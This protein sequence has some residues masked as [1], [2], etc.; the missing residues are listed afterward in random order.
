MTDSAL[1]PAAPFAGSRT[2][3][4]VEDGRHAAEAVR[5]LARRLGMRLR[6]AEDLATARAHLRVYRPDVALVDLGLP[7]GSG[8]DLLADLAALRPPLRRIVAISADPLAGPEA[9]AAGACA[10]VAKPIRLPADLPALFGPDGPLLPAAALP[11][12][13]AGRNA[14]SDPMALRDDL[15]RAHVELE[16]TGVAGLDYAAGFLQGL[17]HCAGD[18]GLQAAVRHARQSRDIAPLLAELAARTERLD[19]RGLI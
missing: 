11:D 13:D 7:D 1:A 4:R 18:D 16:R 3:L 2:L 8:L 10:F 9:L 19:A 5:L 12:P 14:G 6:R 17:A 15:V